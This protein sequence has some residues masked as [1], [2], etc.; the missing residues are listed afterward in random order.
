LLSEVANLV[1]GHSADCSG[2]LIR[3]RFAVLLEC[4]KY[5]NEPLGMDERLD[6]IARYFL[7]RRHASE[8][9][10]AAIGAK[11]LPYLF[12]LQTERDS[13]GALSGLR[14]RLVGTELDRAFARPLTG[15]MLEEFVHGPRGAVVIEA[16]HRCADTSEP[17]WM[18]QVVSVEGKPPRAAE[19]VVIALP[20]DRVYGGLIIGE[21]LEEVAAGSFECQSLRADFATS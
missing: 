21:T 17:V 12:V 1:G 11:L 4:I 9:N 14:I 6:K 3:P 8:V 7:A 15:H 2:V 18:R 20:P 5:Q 19:G 10:P 16:F 13:K